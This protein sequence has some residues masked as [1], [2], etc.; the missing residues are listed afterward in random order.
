M[1]NHFHIKRVLPV[2]LI[3]FA[4]AFLVTGVFLSQ[5]NKILDR[6]LTVAVTALPLNLNPVMNNQFN[7][8]PQ[9]YAY[10][11]YMDTLIW[12]ENNQ[13]TGALAESWTP[14]S[15]LTWEF[16]LR[17]GV[18]FHNGETF[19]A[20]SVKVTFDAFRKR[21]SNP[22]LN[23]VK[24]YEV[25]DDYTFQI[26][27]FVPDATLPAKLAQVPIVPAQYYLQNGED[28]FAAKPIGTGAFE[29]VS[30]ERDKQIVYKAAKNSWRGTPKV[31]EL[32]IKQIADP[33]TQIQALKAGEVDFI[34]LASKNDYD[35][36]KAK[37]YPVYNAMI[38]STVVVDFD[39]I[40]NSLLKDKRVREALNL[41]VDKVA[42]TQNLFGNLT[43]PADQLLASFAL[44]HD[45]SL[46]NL[47]YDPQRAIQLLE[48][49]GI[50]PGQLTLE[51]TYQNGATGRKEA[52]EALQ[53]YLAVIDVKVQ[54]KPLESN[55]YTI[56]LGKNELGFTAIVARVYSPSLD[57]QFGFEALTSAAGIRQRYKN[58]NIE[59]LYANALTENNRAKRQELLRQINR[60]A[61]D[62]Y[63][64][65]PLFFGFDMF[66]SAKTV[67]GFEPQSS[68]YI[69]FELIGKK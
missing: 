51:I 65:L 8:A 22:R 54:A 60:I 69:R 1:S 20:E 36:L 34:K 5:N 64:V 48:Q 67:V 58:T 50:K 21:N 45:P 43:E 53:Q 37:N 59:Q 57:G 41:A 56:K 27:T 7:F 9:L 29:V 66:A 23:T 32:I 33:A 11:A 55:D 25:I 4:C 30:Y 35:D 12:S 38:G 16:K 26:E 2:L 6:R 68:G 10:A 42:L 13:L 28:N 47:A 31:Q 17:K 15:S 18:Q 44:G 61:M 19:T 62:D 14:L 46:K 52:V 49:A 3:L 63:A 40:K 24:K 39:L